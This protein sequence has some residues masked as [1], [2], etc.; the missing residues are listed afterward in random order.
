MRFICVFF[1][2]IFT[3]VSTA[4]ESDLRISLQ[5]IFD[6]LELSSLVSDFDAVPLNSLGDIVTNRGT[7]TKKR[8]KLDA[9][10]YYPIEHFAATSDGKW[11]AVTLLS[12]V[13][14]ANSR[15]KD[16]VVLIHVQDSKATLHRVIRLLDADENDQAEDLE[17][18]SDKLLRIRFSKTNHDGTTQSRYDL[19]DLENGTLKYLSE[20]IPAPNVIDVQA[21]TRFHYLVSRLQDEK[22]IYEFWHLDPKT[23]LATNLGEVK[24]PL[25]G[26]RLMGRFSLGYKR[27]G[28]AQ[29]DLVIL[30][31]QNILFRTIQLLNPQSY[32]YKHVNVRVGPRG[33]KVQDRKY[34]PNYIQGGKGQTNDSNYDAVYK[35]EGGWLGGDLHDWSWDW[36]FFKDANHA[37]GMGRLNERLRNFAVYPHSI[38]GVGYNLGKREEIIFYFYTWSEHAA[39]APKLIDYPI[40]RTL[41][42]GRY[43]VIR[44][45]SDSLGIRDH[46]INNE[47]VMTIPLVSHDF[48]LSESNGDLIVEHF[49]HKPVRHKIPKTRELDK[50]LEC[51]AALGT[52]IWDWKK[53]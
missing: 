2:G 30:D 42:N 24:N 40:L 12:T 5:P 4:A 6:Q 22:L 38:V 29:E 1:I 35:V 14:P 8:V 3:L 20:W 28:P 51:D 47:I 45:N 52:I 23:Q 16:R 39:R 44:I 33:V 34:T 46:S 32:S 31:E 17:F 36:T 25:L 43:S 11:L 41:Q 37:Q 18:V 50:L 48:E 10:P 27:Q 7:K 15:A 9:P 13:L 49:E 26:A 21:H 19:Y 53:L